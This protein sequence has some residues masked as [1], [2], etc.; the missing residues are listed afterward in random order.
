MRYTP[1]IKKIVASLTGSTVP[2]IAVLGDYCL[3]KYL[4]IDADLDEPSVE[5]GLTAYQVRRIETFPG[6]GGTIT[7]NLRSL[8]AKVFCFGIYGE[9]G[10][11][12]DLLKALQKI[13]ADTTGM[14]SSPEIVTSTYMKPMRR[15]NGVWTELNRLDIR[16]AVPS[17]GSLLDKIKEDFSHKVE[18][19]DAVIISDQFTHE[20]GSVL[21]DDFRNFIAETARKHPR[22]FFLGDSR[23]FIEK[24]REIVV[25]CNASE[26][27]AAWNRIQNRE[28]EQF[29]APDDSA[30]EQ[31]DKLIEAGIG[32]SQRNARPVL[33][34]RGSRGSLL[35][36]GDEISEIPSYQVP[37]P[38]DICGAGDATNA[39]FAFGR[40]LGLSLQDSAF[41][42]GIVSSI[43]IQ[44]IGTTGT[45]TIPQLCARLE[46]IDS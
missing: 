3:D 35:F 43:T 5:T 40:S 23:S 22:V 27:L 41:L 37:P 44:Q 28:T 19:C 33:V 30:F 25:K 34:T 31:E 18:M 46:T 1:D 38:I 14:F 42:A 29:V 26:I 36:Q 12:Y 9:D 13:G 20:A 45:A 8:G 39:G 32:M 10:E 11:G 21:T 4:Y 2:V 17:P 16:N 24:Y 15:Q 6:V 7:N